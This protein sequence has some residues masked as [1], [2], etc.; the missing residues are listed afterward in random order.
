MKFPT[1]PVYNIL[2]YRVKCT[3]HYY[4]AVN[5]MLYSVPNGQ[6]MLLQFIDILNTQLIDMLLMMPQTEVGAV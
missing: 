4:C 6:Q 2:H 5:K 1:K 3:T